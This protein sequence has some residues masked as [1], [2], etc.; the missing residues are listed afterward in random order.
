MI[1]DWAR[2]YIGLEYKLGSTGPTH[3]DC[4]GLI[5]WIY[6][7]EYNINISENVYYVTKLDRAIQ[8]EKHIGSWIKV[9]RPEIGNAILF[10]IGGKLPHCG[11]YIGDNKVLHTVDGRMSCIES[12]TSTTWKPRFEGYYKYS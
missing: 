8:L 12:I 2:K 9:D 10:M 11:L 3:F 6:R 7:N 4:W 5:V 1:A